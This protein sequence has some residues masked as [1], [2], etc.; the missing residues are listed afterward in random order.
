MKAGAPITRTLCKVDVAAVLG[1]AEER[2]GIETT[3][4]ERARRALERYDAESERLLA[5]TDGRV[6]SLKARIHIAEEGMSASGPPAPEDVVFMQQELQLA[7]ELNEA[8]LWN[9]LDG[10]QAV[11][12]GFSDAAGR[13]IEAGVNILEL[14]GYAEQ[15][16]T[17]TAD[18]PSEAAERDALADLMDGD[19]DMRGEAAEDGLGE[20]RGA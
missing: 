11:A 2:L 17:L 14:A 6:K 13:M 4:V 15:F 9:R 5:E 10:R 1:V 3:G 12:R 7:E 8:L 18:L 16:V 19:D 20:V